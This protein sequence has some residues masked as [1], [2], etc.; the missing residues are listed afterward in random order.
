M[1][2]MVISFCTWSKLRLAESGASNLPRA[3]ELNRVRSA[4]LELAHL[5]LERR[6]AVA[7]LNVDC[8]LGA[9]ELFDKNIDARHDGDKQGVDIIEYSP[10]CT[11][12]FTA[13][14]V[15]SG[16]TATSSA[17]SLPALELARHHLWADDLDSNERT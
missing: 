11:R 16:R 9:V 3:Q 14:P 13:A 1:T 10:S 6:N 15:A 8:V 5:R 17:G 4:A 2:K 12:A 7:Q